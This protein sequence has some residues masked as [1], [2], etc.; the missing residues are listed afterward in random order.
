MLYSVTDH[1]WQYG[2]CTLHVGYLRLPIHTQV[3]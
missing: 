2:A 3:V 1:R